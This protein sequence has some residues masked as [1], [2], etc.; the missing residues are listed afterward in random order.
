L[1]NAVNNHVEAVEWLL[2]NGADVENIAEAIEPGIEMTTLSIAAAKNH[3]AIV[4][5]LLRHG[6]NVNASHKGSRAL[7]AAA[8]Q[9]AVEAMSLLLLHHAAVEPVDDNGDTPLSQASSTQAVRVLLDH[10]ASLY[11][12]G[13]RGN[14]VLHHAIQCANLPFVEFLIQRGADIHARNDAG[15]TP[16]Q[17]AERGG[18]LVIA[19]KLREAG[20]RE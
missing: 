12:R 15:E 16:L 6:A 4:E 17:L 11:R 14:T 10:G 13:W 2:Q 19:Q 1:S 8:G 20:A 3:A 9:G 5:L 7:H 18:H